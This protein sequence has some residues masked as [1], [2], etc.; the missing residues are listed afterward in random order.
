MS[1]RHRFQRLDPRVL[2]DLLAA[3]QGG[4]LLGGL[5]VADA[6]PA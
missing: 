5:L 6:E 3:G 4:Q 1:D 2:H